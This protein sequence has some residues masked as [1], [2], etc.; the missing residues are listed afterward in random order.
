VGGNAKT[1]TCQEK[2]GR[3]I[4]LAINVCGEFGSAFVGAGQAK[5]ALDD[6]LKKLPAATV[7]YFCQ[8]VFV[9]F[10]GADPR[11]DITGALV[12]ITQLVD[13]PG[14]DAR[15]V[16][17]QMTPLPLAEVKVRLA[18][19][20]KSVIA[21]HAINPA[22]PDTERAD[23]L[24]AGSNIGG[25]DPDS[26][27][28]VTCFVADVDSKAT[29]LLTCHHAI[30]PWR[31]QKT[32]PWIEL[33]LAAGFEGAMRQPEAVTIANPERQAGTSAVDCVYNPSGKFGARPVG[34]FVRGM[35]TPQIS[36]AV[37]LTTRS[38]TNATREGT[39]IAGIASVVKIGDLVWKRGA[40]SRV[41]Q[42]IVTGMSGFEIEH[43]SGVQYS[44]QISARFHN[45]Q[46]GFAPMH[47]DLDD[48]CPVFDARNHLVGMAVGRAGEESGTVIVTPIGRIFEALNVQLAK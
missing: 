39:T 7:Q 36:A 1:E 37:A 15:T 24:L 11:R 31:N 30:R 17:M 40:G 46:Y 43:G 6:K 3:A 4:D 10:D 47:T 38:V 35:R 13:A 48:G 44:G 12:L 2:L 19:R 26:S 21:P 5:P 42:G 22:V 23:P 29:M 28:S 8:H 20:V 16:L 34:H 41:Q 45:D 25:S 27:G 14:P 18:Q 32:S 9:P 33:D